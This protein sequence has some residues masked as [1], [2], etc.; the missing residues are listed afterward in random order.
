M[1]ETRRR[2]DPEF[3]AGAVRIVIEG[4][5]QAVASLADTNADPHT[6]EHSI[7]DELRSL[8]L[9]RAF[10][11]PW[12]D[13]GRIHL[14]RAEAVTSYGPDRIAEVVESLL[15][16]VHPKLL[17]AREGGADESHLFGWAP[18]GAPR[19]EEAALAT[20]SAPPCPR[21]LPSSVD[22]RGLDTAWV[23][24]LCLPRARQEVEGYS[25][26]VWQLTPSGWRCW[27]RDWRLLE[28]GRPS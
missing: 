3:R 5:Q 26:P 2:F 9:R 18:P 1:P 25:T 20:A 22:L 10:P 13:S 23:A 12:L 15:S 24:R 17:R 14:G 6:P 11:A 8:R 16:R 19:N 27:T 28:R 4:L 21:W 7:C